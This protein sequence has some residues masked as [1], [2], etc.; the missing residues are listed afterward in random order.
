MKTTEQVTVI[1]EIPA[2]GPKFT[3][4]KMIL[5]DG[6]P[7][8]M[9]K[10]NLEE[11]IKAFLDSDKYKRA[12]EAELR[13]VWFEF[14]DVSFEHNSATDLMPGSDRPLN[15]LVNVLKNYPGTKIKVGA[16]ADKTG[17]RAVNYAISEQRARNIEAALKK[18]GMADGNISVEGFGERYAEIPETA[19]DAQRAID[20]DIAMRFT[21]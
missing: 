2:P 10:G 3:E 9:Y 6:T 18:A 19:T 11:A 15:T 8:T 16:F 12:S 14:T 17:T 7:I 13:S 20:R 1:H 4:E 21:K 5:P